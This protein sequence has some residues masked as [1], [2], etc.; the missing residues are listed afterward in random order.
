MVNARMVNAHP[1]YF[2]PPSF[3]EFFPALG[4]FLRLQN[5][6]KYVCRFNINHNNSSDE[7]PAMRLFL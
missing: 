7:L 5:P 3:C 6:I 1:A 2:P 4:R